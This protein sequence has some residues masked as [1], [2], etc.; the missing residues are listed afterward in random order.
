MDLNI[1]AK[2]DMESGEDDRMA[3]LETM[4]TV[5]SVVAA[6]LHDAHQ[7]HSSPIRR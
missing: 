4:V 6:H 5:G 1:T 7:L 3:L 2:Q